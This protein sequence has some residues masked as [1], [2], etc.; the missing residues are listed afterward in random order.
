MSAIRWPRLASVSLLRRPRSFVHPLKIQRRKI[1]LVLG[2]SASAGAAVVYCL[3]G[4]Q[5]G[6]AA[7]EEAKHSTSGSDG[8]SLIMRL[9]HGIVGNYD[10]RI[11]EMS[12]PKKIFEYFASEKS[13]DGVPLM[14]PHDFIRSITPFGGREHDLV[15]N[16]AP[17]DFSG[18]PSITLR[19]GARDC[20]ADIPEV[21]RKMSRNGD[22]LLRME[23]Y[24]LL[25]TLLAIP[26]DMFDVAFRMSD[27]NGDGKLDSAEFKSVMAMMYNHSAISRSLQPR[28]K[29][30]RSIIPAPSGFFGSNVHGK[31][32]LTV[33]SFRD[34]L[35]ELRTAVWKMQFNMMDVDGDGKLSAHTFASQILS[36]A[37]KKETTKFKAL[38][39]MLVQGKTDNPNDAESKQQI[40]ATKL[41]KVAF[42]WDDWLA[43]HGMVDDHDEIQRALRLFK[44]AD[45]AGIQRKQLKRLVKV[46]SGYTL[47]EQSID[48]MYFLFDENGDGTLNE[49]EFI[50]LLELSCGHGLQ[51]HRDIGFKRFIRCVG[52]C[53][54][55]HRVGSKT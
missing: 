1:S 36:H 26:P 21:F 20:R 8:S 43:F 4:V 2:A 25:T 51:K 31:K 34:I 55:R 49:E 24:L 42:T 35:V 27:E 3:S 48:L 16:L 30:M 54:Q 53:Y 12:N 23:E 32:V 50:N 39:K 44:A 6:A 7:A 38:K 37:S 18:S 11:R 9:R 17:S 10:N 52:T 41:R 5:R 19:K 15:G 22:G 13:V 28:P 14:S 45:R 29:D 47:T 40:Q 46:V 33:Q